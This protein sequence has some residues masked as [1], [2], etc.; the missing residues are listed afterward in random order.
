MLRQILSIT[1]ERQR[2]S[3]LDA[4]QSN[5]FQFLSLVVTSL[6]QDAAAV[7]AAFDLVLRRKAI[8]AEASAVQHE[9]I[10]GGAYPALA[11]RLEELTTLRRQIAR[12]LL[13]GPGTE[14]RHAYAQRLADWVDRKDRMETELARQIPEMNLEQRLTAAD[15]HAVAL[16]LPQ[17]SVLVEFIRCPVYDFAAV[18]AQG[19][20]AWLPAR[21]LAF[22]V[23]ANAPDEVQ[24]LD[25]GDGESIDAL[26]VTFR[27]SITGEGDGRG[28][29]DLGA[30]PD[31][32]GS[33]SSDDAPQTHGAALR[34][35]ILD[36][37]IGRCGHCTRLFI[38]PDGDLNRLPLEILPLSGDRALDAYQISYVGVGRDVLRFGATSSQTPREPIVLADPA[39]D[40]VMAPRPA[41]DVPGVSRPEQGLCSHPLD[42]GGTTTA[43]DG[44]SSLN[45]APATTTPSQISHDLRLGAVHFARLAGTRLEGEQIA[46]LLAVSPWLSD[47]VLEARLKAYRSP[48]VLHV[49]T[50][51]FFFADRRNSGIPHD[52]VGFISADR[53]LAIDGLSGHGLENPLLK[54]GLALAGANT[55]CRG[56]PLPAEAEDG[57]LTAED[58]S[59]LDLL[60][61]ELVVLS[62]CD[63]G[64]GAVRS[65]EGVFGLR[66]AFILAGARTL[67][68]SLWKVPDEETKILMTD[69]Y[70]RLLAGTPRADAL[71]QSQLAMK[72]RNPSPF[73]WGAFIC[74]GDPGPLPR[75]TSPLAAV[76]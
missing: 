24:L 33:G 34:A 43:P 19:A 60:G 5:Y 37:L 67:I 55:W 21:Y 11:D 54:S 73:F 15:R 10:L 64:L 66:R 53:G 36:P 27:A 42:R 44:A 28:M 13:A 76:G 4:T 30:P 59:G 14:E 57:I 62:A 9:T 46:E 52:K 71:R 63:T 25:L 49:A 68:V 22:V 18:P 48:Y 75:R 51:G 6:A 35:A 17:D 8:S 47:D 45:M 23:Q 50:Q 72:A 61:T 40:L 3:Y 65:G 58:V 39:F 74:I 16:A 2:M 29:R 12:S 26:I 41:P 32:G 7:Q 1:S 69:L 31:L 20:P 56:G 70:R 38:A